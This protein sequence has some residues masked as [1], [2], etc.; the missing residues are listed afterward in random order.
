MG[1]NKSTNI[2]FNEREE[3][4]LRTLNESSDQDRF[5]ENYFHFL[6]VTKTMPS[7]ELEIRRHSALKLASSLYHR[8]VVDELLNSPRHLIGRAMNGLRRDY[9]TVFDYIKEGRRE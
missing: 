2:R 8:L 3:E 5:M 4:T 6:V 7:G 9:K 1:K